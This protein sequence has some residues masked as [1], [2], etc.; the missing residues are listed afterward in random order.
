MVSRLVSP[1]SIGRHLAAIL[2][3]ATLVEID[4]DSHLF[5]RDRPDE[6]AAMVAGHLTK[7]R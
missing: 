1:I 2:P 3:D 5:A 4:D 6:I 7:T